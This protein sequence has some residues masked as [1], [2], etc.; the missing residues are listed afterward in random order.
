M[1]EAIGPCW[2]VFAGCGSAVRGTAFPQLGRGVFG[3][4]CAFGLSVGL[5]LGQRVPAHEVPGSMAAHV[6]GG[7]LG[8][9][10]LSLSS[11]PGGPASSPAASASNGSGEHSPGGSSLRAGIPVTHRSLTPAR[12]TGTAIFADGWALAQR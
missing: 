11:P 10:G 7:I 9:G 12:R 3:I 8:A 6:V 1:A 5:L 4:A 2:V